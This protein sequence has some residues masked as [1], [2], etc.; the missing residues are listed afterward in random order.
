MP[1]G[2][3]CFWATTARVTLP[4]REGQGL[5]RYFH[6]NVHVY[7]AYRHKT[8]SVNYLTAIFTLIQSIVP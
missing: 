8:V 1:L 2:S 5:G 4:A 7:P 6:P 3:N